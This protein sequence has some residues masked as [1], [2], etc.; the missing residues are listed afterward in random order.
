M[1]TRNRRPPA[2]GEFGASTSIAREVMQ[3]ERAR[4][5]AQEQ[6]AISEFHLDAADSGRAVL[7]QRRERLVLPDPESLLDLAG[8]CRLGRGA[9]APAR[10]Q[11]GPTHGRRLESR[12]RWLRK[13]KSGGAR[14]KSSLTRVSTAASGA[15]RSAPCWAIR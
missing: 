2:T 5:H 6:L 13:C 8:E 9:L 4:H 15:R 11:T 1:S 10:P 12:W 7:A 3:L 14:A